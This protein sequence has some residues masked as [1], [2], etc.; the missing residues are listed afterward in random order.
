MAQFQSNKR[1]KWAS[2]FFFSAQQEKGES[3]R[4]Y[5]GHFK[6]AMLEVRGLEPSIAMSA[7]KRGL[8][9]GNFYFFLS[10]RFSR[11]FLELLAHAE[12]YINAEEGIME[13]RKEKGDRKCPFEGFYCSTLSLP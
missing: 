12:K 8:W 5:I 13:K 10:K 1:P 2:D 9:E 4:H 7:L 6:V 3:L 11:S